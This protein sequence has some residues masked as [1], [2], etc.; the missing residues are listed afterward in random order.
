[1]GN[2]GLKVLKSSSL[3]TLLPYLDSRKAPFY[4][5]FSQIDEDPASGGVRPYPFLMITDSDPLTRVLD[6]SLVTDGTSE[7]KRLFV[8]IQKDHYSLRKEELWPF[9]NKDVENAWQKA[10]AAYAEMKQPPLITLCGQIGNRG[11]LRPFQSLLFC[12]YQRFFF[13]PLCPRCSGVLQQCEEDDLLLHSGLQ[14]YSTSLKRYL[15][16]PSCHRGG[17]KDFYVYEL[18]YNDPPFLKDWRSLMK[19]YG[20]LP[21]GRERLP[22]FPC[23]E[24]PDLQGCYGPN[25]QILSRIVPFS[26]YP[27]WMLIFESMSLNASDFIPLISG[28]E[29]EPLEGHLRQEGEAGRSNLLKRVKLDSQSEVPF[30]F[31]HEKKYFSEIL[32]LKLTFLG[33]LIQTLT[34]RESRNHHPDFRPS[35]EKIWVKLADQSPLLPFFWNFHV[36]Y[37][38]IVR[39]GLET[40]SLP[41]PPSSEHLFF[42]GLVWFY[43]L[44]VNDK[45]NF[46]RVS[47]SLQEILDPLTSNR[48]FSFVTVLREGSHATLNPENIFWYPEGRKVQKDEAP[49]WDKSLLLGWSLFKA[50]FGYDLKGLEEE[51]W[52]ELEDLREEVKR[53][54]FSKEPVETPE[55][56]V[57]ADLS[58]DDAIHGILMEILKKWKLETEAGNEEARE[59]VILP[60]GGLKKP[61]PSLGKEAQRVPETV[62]IPPPRTEPG[63]KDKAMA[64]EG[65]GINPRRADEPLEEAGF[66]EETVILDSLK[67]APVSSKESTSRKVGMERGAFSSKEAEAEVIP[68]TKEKPAEDDFLAETVL[69]EP[70]KV[71]EKEKDGKK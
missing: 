62:I 17:G 10:F 48:D 42:L 16:C 31:R 37:I 32:Y 4:L 63:P 54:L 27:F 64:K 49:L 18:E 70:R 5:K 22:Q 1:M 56:K 44:L 50:S 39:P 34:L 13:H 6:A 66:L 47:L 7:I 52:R 15:F 53:D 30:F 65:N 55:E 68:K 59:T 43:V 40:K 51:F 12:R 23:G 36:R 28:A 41:K 38:D 19:E 20:E 25:P 58:Q 69:L 9:N 61:T 35:L 60:A 2:T 3:S 21:A 33:N 71:R 46:S 45:Q 8:L 11:T 67:H 57:T 29:I 26:F 24:C 14:P